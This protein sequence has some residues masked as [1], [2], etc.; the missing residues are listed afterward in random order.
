MGWKRAKSISIKEY[1]HFDNEIMVSKNADALAVVDF[2]FWNV[3]PAS[4]T[5]ISNCF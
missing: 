5:A 2:T 3:V 4:I 1:V